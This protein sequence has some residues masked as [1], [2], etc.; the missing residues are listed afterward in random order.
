MA[1]PLHAI[2]LDVLALPVRRALVETL[3]GKVV[4]AAASAAVTAGAGAPRPGTDILEVS[5]RV[6]E[7]AGAALALGR[8]ASPGV[9]RRELIR[10]DCRELAKDVVNL[11][12]GRRVV[13]HPPCA[14]LTER[15]AT[16]LPMPLAERGGPYLTDDEAILLYGGPPYSAFEP[17]APSHIVVGPCETTPN[18]LDLVPVATA[19]VCEALAGVQGL[20]PDLGLSGGE[21]VPEFL[22]AEESSEKQ[23]DTDGQL[24]VASEG[25]EAIAPVSITVVSSR[26]VCPIDVTMTDSVDA[27]FER[28][29]LEGDKM[30][31]FYQGV[32]LERSGK[33]SDYGICKGDFVNV[34]E[35]GKLLKY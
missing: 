19:P 30:S 31:M 3:M 35:I 27:I 12:H 10:R 9:A 8:K 4:T 21:D 6:L 14:D 32:K 17:G 33:V 13:A 24:V 16:A 25:V 20:E 5:E 2:L 1:S 29:G 11:S 28:T 15:V 18:T 34:I 22:A 26:G 7:A 23:L